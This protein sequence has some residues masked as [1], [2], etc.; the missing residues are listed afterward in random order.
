M[1][2]I[3]GRSGAR[4]SHPTDFRNYTELLDVVANLLVIVNGNSALPSVRN[5]LTDHGSWVRSAS[6]KYSTASQITEGEAETEEDEAQRDQRHGEPVGP[7]RA[8]ALPSLD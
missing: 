7:V 8:V 3:P 6:P 4:H 5:C 1:C 2:A